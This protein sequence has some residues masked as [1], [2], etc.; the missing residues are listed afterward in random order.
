MSD[1]MYYVVN[2]VR[3]LLVQTALSLGNIF[4]IYILQKYRAFDK[5]LIYLHLNRVEYTY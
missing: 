4:N 2:F 1:N 3:G 5:H